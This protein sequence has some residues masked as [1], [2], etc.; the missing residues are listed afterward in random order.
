M[1]TA[2]TPDEALAEVRGCAKYGR[3][4][5]TA[6]AFDRM[7][8]R[9]VTERELVTA[10]CNAHDCARSPAKSSVLLGGTAAANSSRSSS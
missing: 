8:E 9:G 5:I 6:H 2:V 1:I 4:T 7:D 10:L 3:Y